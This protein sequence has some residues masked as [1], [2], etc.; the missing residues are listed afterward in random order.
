MKYFLAVFFIIFSIHKSLACSCIR[1]GILKGQNQ[2]DFIFTGK[3]LEINKVITKE[4]TTG[5]NKI[6]DFI[7]YEFIFEIKHKHKGKKDLNF[8]DT[9]TIISTAGGADCGKNFFFK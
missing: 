9:I 7:H 2:S 5:S 4:K 3:V 1:V 8:R 6:K